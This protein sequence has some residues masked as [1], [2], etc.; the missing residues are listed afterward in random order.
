MIRVSLLCDPA[1]VHFGAASQ[2]SVFLFALSVELKALRNGRWDKA[3]QKEK[4]S[5]PEAPLEP[6]QQLENPRQDRFRKATIVIEHLIQAADVAHMSQHWNIYRKWNEL[7][8]RE[9]YKAYRQGRSST[10]PAD[11]W[12]KGEIGFFDFYSK[13]VNQQLMI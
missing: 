7:L 8:Y 9:M 4:Q 2:H 3:F 12:Y 6:E 10:N 1:F 5:D 13:F 11:G